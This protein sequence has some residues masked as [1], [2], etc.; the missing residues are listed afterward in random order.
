MRLLYLDSH[1]T[2]CLTEFLGNKI[3]HP[4]AILSRTWRIDHGEVKFQDISEGTAKSKAGYDKIRFCG[5]KAARDG[6][7]YFWV[8]SCCTIQSHHW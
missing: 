4:Y 1:E 2:P 6:L 3:P 5:G 8:D 7:E